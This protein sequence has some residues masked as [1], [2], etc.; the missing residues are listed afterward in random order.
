[1]CPVLLD[2]Q[3]ILQGIAVVV[4]EDI[5]LAFKDISRDKRVF[6]FIVQDELLLL[7]IKYVDG[8]AADV[9]VVGQVA[10]LFFHDMFI[11]GFQSGSI[12]LLEPKKAGKEDDAEEE[13]AGCSEGRECICSC[14]VLERMATE[15]I[16]I[17]CL[18]WRKAPGFVQ[19]I[20]DL[21]LPMGNNDQFMIV[22]V[23][24]IAI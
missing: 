5:E 22:E 1:M 15:G 8:A 7:F 13:H 21:H 14:S 3:G 20:K 10:V 18:A 16:V 17:A 19:D 23:E 4:L 9:D 12:E 24:R 11:G 6:Q 2:H